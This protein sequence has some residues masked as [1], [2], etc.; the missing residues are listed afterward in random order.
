MV[1]IDLAQDRVKRSAIVIINF[2]V[3]KESV[4]KF[5]TVGGFSRRAHLYEVS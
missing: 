1:C 4:G 5:C 3:P 2:W